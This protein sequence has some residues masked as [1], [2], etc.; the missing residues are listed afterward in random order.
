MI[1]RW[2]LLGA[3]LVA[4]GQGARAASPS[5]SLWS[6]AKAFETK[7]SRTWNA[8]CE[9]EAQ[10]LNDVLG[11]DATKLASY[12]KIQVTIPVP[13]DA[14]SLAEIRYK[15]EKANK[16]HDKNC[17]G[18]WAI[19]CSELSGFMTVLEVSEKI[20]NGTL[21]GQEVEAK[22][23]AAEKMAE[24]K[25]IADAKA[26]EEARV[27]R[28]ADAARAAEE[29]RIAREQAQEQRQWTLLYLVGGVTVL[30]FGVYI[31][32]RAVGVSASLSEWSRFYFWLVKAAVTVSFALFFLTAVETFFGALSIPDWMRRPLADMLDKAS[33]AIDP[34]AKEAVK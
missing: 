33:D 25:R 6:D 14:S 26:A 5:A 1:L 20:V 8:D 12:Y 17:T 23:L 7:C 31:A 15:L 19:G 22:R 32:L 24:E 3:L 9:A 34:E 13:I 21:L 29:R 11:E 18:G 16:D 10:R 27:K 30:L 2:V 28:E 4:C